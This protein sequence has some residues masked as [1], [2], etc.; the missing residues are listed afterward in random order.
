MCWAPEQL[1]AT[2]RHAFSCLLLVLLLAADSSMNCLCSAYNP[3]MDAN[4]S[5]LSPSVLL[6]GEFD[7][8]MSTGSDG[9]PWSRCLDSVWRARAV[10]TGDRLNFV[11]THHWLPGQDGTGV[12][13]FC[14]LHTTGAAGD[15]GTCLPFT[16]GKIA[17]FR[18]SMT[19]C[20]AEAIRQ[21][22]VPYVRP[23]LDDGL[24]RYA[25]VAASL[26]TSCTCN[27]VSCS[28]LQQPCWSKGQVASS[29][30]STS[31]VHVKQCQ[32]QSLDKLL[33][34]QCRHQPGRAAAQFATQLQRPGTQ[35]AAAGHCQL[36]SHNARLCHCAGSLRI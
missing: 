35:V 14:Y 19:Y 32:Q 24:N 7:W 17:E 13:A 1:A 2:R 29:R 16:S 21:G 15:R 36:Q 18:T 5:Q 10:S 26:S 12:S 27:A 33:P 31:H 6:M 3:A 23:H 8:S 20:F 34:V 28:R 9:K 22:F 25:P 30:E 11:P 4:A